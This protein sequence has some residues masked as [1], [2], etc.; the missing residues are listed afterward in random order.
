[1]LNVNNA[2]LIK[3]LNPLILKYGRNS[4]IYSIIQEKF[5]SRGLTG[6][7]AK[8]L[9]T[10]KLPLETLDINNPKELFL[11]FAFT[12]SMKE[13]LSSYD[14]MSKNTFGASIE[15]NK[16]R[17]ENYFTPMEI[18]EF[19]DFVIEKE[20]ISKYPYRLKNMLKVA[21]GHYVGIIDCKEFARIDASNDIVYDFTVQR[22]PKIDVYGMKRIN[23][24]LKK[25]NE[26]S[27]CLLSGRYD[28]DEIKLNVEKDGEDNLEF[29]S[30]DGI[31][32][33]L[34]IH[35]GRITCFDGYSRKSANSIANNKNSDLHM[36]WKLCITN[37]PKFRAKRFMIQVNKQKPIN[38]EHIKNMD[39]T[40]NE[41]VIVGNIINNPNSELADKIKNSDAD[42]KHGGLTKKSTLSIAIEDQYK[43][44]LNSKIHNIEI[45]DWI[46]DFTNYLMSIYPNEFIDNIEKTKLLSYIN[47][48]NMF[49]GYIGLS[50]RFYK[51][52]NWKN[53]VKD[54]MNNIDFSVEN[55][56]WN[57]IRINDN[58]LNKTSRKELY[59]LFLEEV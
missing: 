48:R 53:K 41:N 46:V 7:N 3:E 28:S 11:L 55:N 38:Y 1:M 33:E 29:V 25:I 15:Y 23:V 44:F 35:S 49:I 9:L 42:L 14:E 5:I 51:Q 31:Y 20:E 21:E 26:I 39:E 24:D 57:N 30:K 34:I 58:N 52:D 22:D 40:K 54:I 59:N 13:A 47:H 50:K 18:E 4:K 37:F 43:E 45:S 12:D 32:G 17:L 36:N 27:E 6:S 19:K 8:N 10:G 16:L 2:M 56:I